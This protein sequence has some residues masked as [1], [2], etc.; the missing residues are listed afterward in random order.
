MPVSSSKGLSINPTQ[1]AG[2]SLNSSFDYVALEGFDPLWS[3]F[4]LGVLA[5]FYRTKVE[6]GAQSP[7]QNVLCNIY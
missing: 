1:V 6:V 3:F 5:I 2:N 7:Q 4:P